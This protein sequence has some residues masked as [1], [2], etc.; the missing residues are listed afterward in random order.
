MER[1][2]GSASGRRPGNRRDP[3]ASLSPALYGSDRR[4]AACGGPTLCQRRP[5]PGHFP[6]RAIGQN[7]SVSDSPADQLRNPDAV[8]FDFD[9]TIIDSRGP[10]VRSINHTLR[11]HGHPEQP[12]ESLYHFLGPPTHVTFQALIGDD[13]EELRSAVETYRE[14]Y[15]SLG[16]DGTE[17]YDGVRELLAQ[18]HGRVTVALATSKV[19]T[20]TEALLHEL[21]LRSYFD[22]VCGPAPDAINE[23]KADTVA[24]T[25]SRL[26]AATGAGPG[27]ST[28]AGPTKPVR[29]VMIGDRKYDVIGAG[30]NGVPTI[31]VLWGAGSEEELHESGVT[32]VV[33]DPAEIPALLGLE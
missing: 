24:R 2:R 7:Q 32:A 16:A 27:T 15:F 10:F 1:P 17:V 31:G 5:H 25:L 33:S 23:P 28:D 9:G 4:P 30:A 20:M 6:A 14:H 13:E 26:H 19:I 18:L 21:D 8:L 11:V 29:A 3:A 22:V 12:A